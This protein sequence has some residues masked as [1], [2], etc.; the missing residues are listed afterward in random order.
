MEKIIALAMLLI[1]FVSGCTSI[2]TVSEADGSEK[3]TSAMWITY[4]EINEMLLS[5]NGF[6][7]E[8][9]S[10]SEKCVSL[11]ISEVYIHV[12]SHCDSLFKSELFPLKKEAENYDGDAFG[13][14]L[15]TFH[16]VGIKVHAW[17]NPYRVSTAGTDISV[18]DKES[19]AYKW[20]NDSDPQNDLN[21]CLSDGIYLNPGEAEVISLIIDGVK[22]I[23]EKYSVDG[24]HFDDYFYPT[25]ASEFDSE[26]YE[27]YTSDTQNPLSLGEWRRTNVNLLI[28]G[29]HNVVEAAGRVFSVSPAASPEKNRT[30]LFA[31]VE[32]WV[33]NGYVDRII[34]QLYFGFE[35][36]DEEYRFD[37]LLK[38]WEKISTLNSSVE[39]YIGLAFY[40][41]GTQSTADGDEW[42]EKDDITARQAEAC[43]ESKCVKGCVLFSYSSVFSEDEKNVRQTENYKSAMMT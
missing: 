26:S 16:S 23:T 14:I 30:E 4:S 17:I 1:I 32:H 2:S 24:I 3:I 40:K 25:S 10:A 35:Y 34:P 43:R 7:A 9:L 13:F 36:A 33:K 6:E 22:E 29:C 12:R 21:V 8:A 20:L 15:N 37:R 5:E 41:T 31:D 39:L 28:S 11:G 27:K 18:L 38:K 42:L 19:P